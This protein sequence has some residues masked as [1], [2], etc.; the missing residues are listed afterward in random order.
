MLPC[1]K[2]ED[3]FQ[4]DLEEDENGTFVGNEKYL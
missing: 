1:L 3:F 4:E 2:A